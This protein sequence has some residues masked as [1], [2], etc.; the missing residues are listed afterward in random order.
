ML[1]IRHSHALRSISYRHDHAD[2][3]DRMLAAQSDLDSIPL[4]TRDP[5]HSFLSS[6]YGESLHR[7][8]DRA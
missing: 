3:F 6:W 1:A 2:P 7:D 8:R 4:V 5:A